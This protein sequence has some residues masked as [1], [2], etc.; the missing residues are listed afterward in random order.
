MVCYDKES[1][2]N[3]ENVPISMCHTATAEYIL[4]TEIYMMLMEI[5]YIIAS[6]FHHPINVTGRLT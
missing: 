4:F 2:S 3:M 5:M 1:N 6:C